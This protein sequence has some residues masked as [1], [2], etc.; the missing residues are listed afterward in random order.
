MQLVQI[1]WIDS[2]PGPN[3]W[4][5]LD[6]IESLKPVLCRTVG[7]L[8]EDRSEYKTLAQSLSDTQVHGRITIPKHCI[9]RIKRLK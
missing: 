9:K 6:G 4:E 2:K 8:M 7:F 5:Y 1:D 3:E